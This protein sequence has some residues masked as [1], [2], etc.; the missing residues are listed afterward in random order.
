MEETTA[1]FL[2]IRRMLNSNKAMQ[3]FTPPPTLECDSAQQTAGLPWLHGE[4]ATAPAEPVR[5]MLRVHNR[6]GIPVI[7]GHTVVEAGQQKFIFSELRPYGI[8][9]YA[10]ASAADRE[11]VAQRVWSRRAYGTIE[12]QPDSARR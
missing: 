4:L 3:R 12:I 1:A 10:H 6:A 8:E 5:L 2:E 7:E 11:Q 9:A